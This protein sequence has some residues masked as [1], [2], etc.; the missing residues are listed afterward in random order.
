[1]YVYKINIIFHKFYRE[2]TQGLH[3]RDVNSLYSRA[4]YSRCK[5]PTRRNVTSFG[6]VPRA[7]RERLFAIIFY[8]GRN[9]IRSIKTTKKNDRDASQLRWYVT[10]SVRGGQPIFLI[11]RWF[12]LK[13]RLARHLLSF[14]LRNRF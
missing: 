13:S 9:F 8:L 1:M 14:R 10:P 3:H 7:L 5:I 12:F 6:F 11:K 2:T 4:A